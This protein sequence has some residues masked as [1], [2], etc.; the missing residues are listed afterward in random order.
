MVQSSQEQKTKFISYISYS[1]QLLITSYIYKYLIVFSFVCILPL[2]YRH[3]FIA[4]NMLYYIMF[5]ISNI[6]TIF[7]S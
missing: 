2:M 7:A 3:L 6:K 1:M 4:I 5:F